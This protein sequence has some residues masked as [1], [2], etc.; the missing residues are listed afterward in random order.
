[1]C[2]GPRSFV[3]LLVRTTE[4]LQSFRLVPFLVAGA[5]VPHWLG[6]CAWVDCEP[7]LVLLLIVVLEVLLVVEVRAAD[8][9]V[10]L[11]GMCHVDSSRWDMTV[12]AQR[13]PGK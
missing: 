8:D 4:T 12:R 1:M 9:A 13:V 5:L 11:V 3:A 10:V 2:T 7:R 6:G